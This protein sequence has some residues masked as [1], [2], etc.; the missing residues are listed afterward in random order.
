MSSEN[1]QKEKEVWVGEVAFIDDGY[2]SWDAK[3]VFASE[4][5]AKHWVGG[6]TR[7]RTANKFPIIGEPLCEGCKNSAWKYQGALDSIREHMEMIAELKKE[8]EKWVNEAEAATKA[9][10]ESAARLRT[11]AAPTPNEMAAEIADEISAIRFDGNQRVGPCLI[12]KLAAMATRL[13]TI[14]APQ[15]NEAAADVMEMLKDELKTIAKQRDLSILRAEKSKADRDHLRNEYKTL[16]MSTAM[17]VEDK[18]ETIERLS[19]ELNEAI[20]KQMRQEVAHDKTTARLAA[21]EEAVET[22]CEHMTAHVDVAASPSPSVYLWLDTL[23]SATKGTEMDCLQCEHYETSPTEDPCCTRKNNDR[24]ERTSGCSPATKGTGTAETVPAK[25]WVNG[26]NQYDVGDLPRA[27]FWTAKQASESC[28]GGMTFCIPVIGTP[29]TPKSVPTDCSDCRKEIEPGDVWPLCG[30]C[31]KATAVPPPK[32]G[33]SKNCD[34]LSCQHVMI[35]ERDRDEWKAHHM[36]EM[37]KA[38]RLLN[39]DSTPPPPKSGQSE[40]LKKLL[41]YDLSVGFDADVI[42]WI[43]RHEQDHKGE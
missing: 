9:A 18:N 21:L 34:P 24:F 4:Q 8:K 39:C 29:P 22:V 26:L 38:E 13:R 17:A 11:L 25:V 43:E 1:K 31:Y 12:G 40:L 3:C 15:P 19:V 2:R 33:P 6:D 20:A 28:R 10:R 16:E 42:R 32:S 27:V 41:S 35:A 36:E 14:A 23:R 37:A 7:N 5:D 30:E